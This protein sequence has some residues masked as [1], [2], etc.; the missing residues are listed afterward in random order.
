MSLQ[1]TVFQILKKQNK[2]NLIMILVIG[3]L[4]SVSVVSTF[5]GICL[6]CSYWVS[7][8]LN[9]IIGISLIIISV[10]FISCFC[11]YISVRNKPHYLMRKKQ[12][13]HIVI[14]KT[15][16]SKGWR[17]DEKFNKTDDILY[18]Y[19]G[20]A[21]I[22]NYEDN[23]YHSKPFI[24]EDENNVVHTFNINHVDVFID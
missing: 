7:I 11:Y 16:D 4:L 20:L 12:Q 15:K 1:G 3:L 21:R 17:L 23:E 13:R 9:F 5:L 24:F 6:A 22:I 19:S 8:S 10:I 2:E 18:E 14:Q